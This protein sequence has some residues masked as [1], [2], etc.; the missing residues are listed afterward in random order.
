ML[1][2][3]HKVGGVCIGVVTTFLLS[4][5]AEFA[6]YALLAAPLLIGSSMFGSLLPDI[7]HPNSMMGRRVKPISKLLN[8]TVGHRGATHTILALVM[9]IVFL[10]MIN[11]S[12]P[13]QIQ[14]FGW[15]IVLGTGVGY[16]SHLLL[17]AL[18][19]SG[20]PLFAPF[21]RKSIRIA[22]L[23]TG[24]YDSIVSTF[25]IILTVLYMLYST[26]NL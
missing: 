15:S 23:T 16:F 5:R 4:Q 22:R 20:V 14:P 13:I 24:R 17:D 21:Y 11:L 6:E 10:F 8:K 12:L 7:D 26:I 2:K 25:M 3:T 1:G 9:V 19:P 18:T